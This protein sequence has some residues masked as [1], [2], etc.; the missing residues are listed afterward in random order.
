MERNVARFKDQKSSDKAFIDTRIPGHEREIFSIIGNGVQ[1]DASMRPQIPAQ[2]F[3]LA[4]IRSEPGK[5]AAL[6][7]HL[8]QE[9][10]MPLSGRWAIF[11]GPNGEKEV[12]LEPYDVIS[13]PLHVM[14]GFRNAGSETAMMLAVVGGNDPG[15]VGWPAS[16]KDAA[17]AAGLILDEEGNLREVAPA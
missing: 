15:R 14:R 13:V 2:D 10:F 6:H 4:M 12:I 1:E 9:V 17:R 7:S 5:G 11:W 8:T 16:M 3:H